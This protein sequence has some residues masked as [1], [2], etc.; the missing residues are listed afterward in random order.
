[1]GLDIKNVV[2]DFLITAAFTAF[3]YFV[4]PWILH[5][6]WYQAIYFSI[7]ITVSNV[8]AVMLSWAYFSKTRC[9]DDELNI[10]TMIG[11]KTLGASAT[12]FI[13]FIIRIVGNILAVVFLLLYP[14]ILAIEIWIFIAPVRMFLLTTAVTASLYFYEMINN[15]I[16]VNGSK[17]IQ[18]NDRSIM[19][20]IMKDPIFCDF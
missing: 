14:D 12:H 15:A 2:K 20:K 10:V 19:C 16:A 5:S 1:M 9:Y 8:L 17:N 13:V 6:S 3:S 7:A 4:I 18:C 11:Y